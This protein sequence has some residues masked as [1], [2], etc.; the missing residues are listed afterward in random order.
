MML[1][2]MKLL[3]PAVNIVLIQFFSKDVHRVKNNRGIKSEMDFNSW[4]SRIPLSY[5]VS[6]NP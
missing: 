2:L 6:H 4:S 5:V 3:I 1:C